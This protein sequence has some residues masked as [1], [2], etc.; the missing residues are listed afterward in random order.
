MP[1]EQALSTPLAKSLM[2]KNIFVYAHTVNSLKIWKQLNQTG[3]AGI[4]TD[5]FAP[6]GGSGE[7]RLN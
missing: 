7:R 3:V 1:V 6:I 4:Y 2:G 5:V